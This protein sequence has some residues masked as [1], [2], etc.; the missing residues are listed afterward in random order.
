MGIA[1]R[2][3]MAARGWGQGKKWGHGG[4]CASMTRNMSTGDV[5]EPQGEQ[6]LHPVAGSAPQ[7]LLQLG[8]SQLTHIGPAARWCV[9]P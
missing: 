3:L 2:V 7:S 5:K 6:G 4:N 9:R 8:C 1:N